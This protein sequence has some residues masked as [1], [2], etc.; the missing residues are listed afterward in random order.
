MLTPL[1]TF[2]LSA[3]LLYIP[4]V[5]RWAIDQ[6]TTYASD[7]FGM[8]IRI[9][10]VRVSFPLDLELQG[11]QVIH[12]EEA[13]G[14]MG[15][16]VVDLDLMRILLL[17]IRIEGIE[18]KDLDVETGNLIESVHINGNLKRI[19]LKAEQINLLDAN[20][21]LAQASIEGGDVTICLADTTAAD[22]TESSPLP[23]T[24]GIEKVRL[25][26][27][28]LSL[29]MPLDSLDLGLQIREG[30]LNDGNI[31]LLQGIYQADDIHIKTDTIR[32][33]AQTDTLEHAGIDFTLILLTETSLQLNNPFYNQTSNAAA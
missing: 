19:F 27:L 16:M 15:S 18:L 31:D 5:Q 24:I 28:N 2:V 32:Y 6:A 10:R 29:Q 7:E 8:D 21:S 22:T 12:Q 26:R 30:E 17:Q 9:D 25:D 3:V 11:L 4:P 23:W 14:S 20:V 1:I 13:L 33:N